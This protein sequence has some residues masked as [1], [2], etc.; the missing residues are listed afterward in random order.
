MECTCNLTHNQSQN[1]SF[2]LPRQK[3]KEI[4][5]MP[6]TRRRRRTTR[7]IY[8]PYLRKFMSWK[9]G[10]DHPAGTEFTQAQLL[11]IRPSHIVRYM[12]LLSYGDENPG[13]GAQ[14]LN[15]RSTGMEVVK[16]AI[17]YFMPNQNAKW[18]VEHEY[19]NPT[20]SVAVNNVIKA[21]KKLEVRKQGKK[22]N[23]K[24]DLKRPE[25]RKSLRLLESTV[26]K[27]Q[28]LRT[29]GMLKVQFHIIGRADDISNLE[30]CDLRQHDKFKAFCLQTKV[31]WSKNVLEE[32]TCPDQILLG[33]MDSDFCVL[34]GL[35]CY[36]ES[37]FSSFQQAPNGRRFLFGQSD[38]DD[39]P[40]RINERYQRVL[41]KVWAH[42]E[43]KQLV[44][45]V[46]GGIGSHSI[47]K[48]PATWAAEH[49]ISQDHIEIRGRWKGGRNGRTVNRYINVEQLPTDGHVAS[50]L[51]VGGPVKYKPRPG[52]G[53]THQFLMTHVVPGIKGHFAADESNKIAEVLALPVLWAAFQPGLEHMMDPEVR[54]RIRN[55]Y[56]G[57]RPNDFHAHWNPIVKVALIVTRVENNLCIDEMQVLNPD[58]APDAPADPEVQEQQ[59]VHAQALNGHTAQLQAC[60]NQVHLC[61]TQLTENQQANH[62]ALAD[63]KGWMQIKFESQNRNINRLKQSAPFAPRVAPQG[64][65][66]PAANAPPQAAPAEVPV[67]QDGFAGGPGIPAGD[68]AQ[69]VTTDRGP[70]RPMAKLS[71]KPKSIHD[72]W[73][74]YQHGIGGNILARQFKRRERGRCK[75]TYS[76]RNL[77]WTVIE[78]LVLAGLDA[79]VACD[80][81][82]QAYGHNKS[83]TYIINAMYRDK[84]LAGGKDAVGE[85]WKHPN[86]RVGA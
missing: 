74:E 40:I 80:R 49:G 73:Q 4:A 41:R 7:E 61:R 24:R 28:C 57:I 15:R 23:A 58:A 78:D 65:A 44:A 83:L 36:L 11:T 8:K 81:I 26:S 72:L 39:E 5:T 62:Q 19:G 47:R 21:I 37:R 38:E 16:K 50:I 1:H 27:Q 77:I 51:S 85:S 31:S 84:R 68:S 66:A 6:R 43:M 34:L 9:D 75:H 25:F 32:R 64:Q 53:L 60:L 56:D 69:D 46:R 52:S 54:T 30:T 82:Y 22:S 55:A 12:N 29:S 63:L 45:Q 33:S 70:P 18:N 17:S 35:G 13:E 79:D 86:L 48:F 71:D 14:P 67:Q 10:Q 3:Q 76:R 20:M 2:A 42:E 59:V